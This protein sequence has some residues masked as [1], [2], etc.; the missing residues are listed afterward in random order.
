MAVF[1]A[2]ARLGDVVAVPAANETFLLLSDPT[3]VR[4]VLL[5]EDHSRR[6][7]FEVPLIRRILGEGALTTDGAAWALARRV[8]GPPLA[9]RA[10]GAL[11]P[12]LRQ[13]V[14]DRLEALESRAR[15][16][17]PVPVFPE[18]T[19]L[20]VRVTVEG[21]LG[22]TLSDGEARALAD[23]VLF[24]QA[25]LFFWLGAPWRAV[26]H[27]PTQANRRFHTTVA[28]LEALVEAVLRSAPNSGFVRH[29]LD[30]RD[31]EGQP[32]GP[33]GQRNHLLTQ[34]VAAPENT[35]TTLSWTLHL[36]STHP[37]VQA[38]LRAE[39]AE[40]PL[41][42]GVLSEALRLY[43]GAPYLDRRVESPT[44]IAGHPVARGTLLM[45][46]PYLLH[47]DPRFWEAPA[48]F[49]PERADIADNQ[50]FLP[51]GFGP[52]RCVGEHF[53]MAVLRAM[54]PEL[55]A[56]F[57]VHPAPGYVAAIDPVINLR[58]LAGM[59][60]LLRPIAAS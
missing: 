28:G 43:P 37:Q 13:L 11:G 18:M 47:R 41:W 45:M 10:V 57:E 22:A 54:L 27:V 25:Y 1:E 14:A 53:A 29:L 55:L 5:R 34:L 60:L 56:R 40:S 4:D 16:G 35:A 48:E 32:L 21:L 36:L 52:R 51:F 17:A 20:T 46:A 38:R 12:L 3:L 19:A 15:D 8:A 9:P 2:A 30:M 58:P 44:S 33:T 26:P 50:A 7:N 42:S 6:N 31:P 49:R 59:P 24:A 23:E 39:G